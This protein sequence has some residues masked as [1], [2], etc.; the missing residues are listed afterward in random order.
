MIIWEYEKTIN[1]FRS[2]KEIRS[3]WFVLKFFAQRWN[4]YK[5][6]GLEENS[7]VAKYPI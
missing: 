4:I 2:N 1:T 6:R 5:E 3:I 7:T